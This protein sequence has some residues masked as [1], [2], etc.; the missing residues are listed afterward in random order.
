MGLYIQKYTWNKIEHLEHQ[1]RPE[2]VITE[3]VCQ[4]CGEREATTMPYY[5]F[6]HSSQEYLRICP[7]CEFDSLKN[8]IDD[9]VK[10]VGFVRSELLI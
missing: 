8:N 2:T 7:K 4:V 5:L 9:F 1:P 3:W 6:K 10:L